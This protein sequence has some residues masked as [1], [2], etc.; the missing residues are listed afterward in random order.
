MII[1]KVLVQYFSKNFRDNITNIDFI[2][3]GY[4][5]LKELNLSNFNTNTDMGSMF[6]RRSSLKELNISIF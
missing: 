5:E 4:S 2:L 3:Y 1:V 6:S